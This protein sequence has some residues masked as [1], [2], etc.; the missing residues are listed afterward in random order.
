MVTIYKAFLA[1]PGDTKE[2]REIADNVINEINSSIGVLH[3]FRVELLKWEKDSYPSLGED[4]QAVINEQLGSDYDIFI[5]IMF[6]KFGSPTLRAESGTEEE[7]MRAYESFKSV[8]NK[9]IMFYFNM[10]PLPQQDFNLEQYGKVLDFKQKIAELGCYYFQYNNAKEFEGFF[11]KHLTKTLLEEN[12]NKKVPISSP[13]TNPTGGIIPE[14]TSHFDEYLN[15]TEASFAHS[16]KDKLTLEDIYVPPDLKDLRASTKSVHYKTRNIESLTNAID[17]E[18]IKYVFIGTE[19]S[20]KTTNLKYLYRKYFDLGLIPIFL[21]GVDI[22]NNIRPDSFKKLIESKIKEQYVTPFTYNTFPKENYV[23][24]IDDFHKSTKGLEK[25]Q[26]ILVRNINSLFTNII[27]TGTHIMLIENVTKND[28]LKDFSLFSILEFGPKNRDLL[29]KKWCT[30]GL[31][32]R[33]L[34]KNEQYRKSD[35]IHEH[36]NTIIGKNYI[37]SYPFYLLTILQ[38]LEATTIS[39][40]N[41]SIH[42]FYYELIINESLNKAIKDKREISLYYNYLTFFCFFLFEKNSTSLTFDEFNDFHEK[43]CITHDLTYKSTSLLKR[44]EEARVFTINHKIAIKERFVYYFFVAKY[45]ANNINKKEIKELVTKMSQ[46][47]FRDEYASIIMFVTHLSKDEF[48]ID[49]LIKNADSIFTDTVPAKLEDDISLINSL[50][51]GI[52]EQVL[53]A[54][55]SDIVREEELMEDDI[56]EQIEKEYNEE[57]DDEE[58]NLD[59]DITSIDFFSKFTLAL[60][61]IDILGQITKKYWGEINGEQKLNLVYSTYNL[62]LRTLNIYLQF[63]QQNSD[64]IIESIS[65]II[66]EKHI[67]DRFNLKKEIEA[68]TKDFVFELCFLATWAL[69]KRVSASIGY[70]KLRNT[71]EK[72][73]TNNPFNS[74][75]LIDLAIKLTHT[76]IPT[77]LI[78]G[79]AKEMENNNLSYVTLQNLVIDHLYMFDTDH[80]TKNKICSALKISVKKQLHIDATSTTK[81]ET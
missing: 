62:G 44:F 79:Y 12:I 7:F 34:D 1:S 43:Y 66:R 46:R 28:I 41:Y 13:L 55:D 38:S 59:D 74:F 57:R 16:R 18:G 64:E 51:E 14:I 37:P 77:E 75:K 73:L 9:K 68:V 3:D 8:G 6:K 70:D 45:I 31:E 48:I 39:N 32:A 81:R 35:Q 2:E 24:L 67:K 42:G 63:I 25:F 40:T 23:L 36:V 65:E 17:D 30:L 27:L 47:L 20:G 26:S 22:K 50:V 58:L 29:I 54:I 76:G 10:S 5:G 19:T 71:Y 80:V 21:N 15:D 49:E 11:R 52:P 69:T 33:F 60:K 72:V 78:K 53:R 61:T 56:N 4:G